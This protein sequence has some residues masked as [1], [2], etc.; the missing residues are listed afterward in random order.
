MWILSAIILYFQWQNTCYQ[1]CSD[2]RLQ[3]FI[4]L[5]DTTAKFVLPVSYFDHITL[6][7]HLLVCLH[8]YIQIILFHL[9]NFSQDKI[10]ACISAILRNSSIPKILCISLSIVYPNLTCC[11]ENKIINRHIPNTPIK[12]IQWL[13]NYLTNRTDHCSATR[14]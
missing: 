14:V 9:Q 7:I 11:N 2:C 4:V 13:K 8:S 3:Q 1:I 12:M 10:Q 6:W 5:Q